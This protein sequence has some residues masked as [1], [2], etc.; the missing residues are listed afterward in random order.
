MAKESARVVLG[1]FA[2][3][4]TPDELRAEDRMMK[5]QALERFLTDNRF[6]ADDFREGLGRAVEMGWIRKEGEVLT[7]TNRGL[8]ELPGRFGEPK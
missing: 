4:D 2:R 1:V 6:T 8:A 3:D 5:Q 7:L